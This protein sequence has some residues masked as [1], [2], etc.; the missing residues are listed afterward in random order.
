MSVAAMHW[1]Y[2]PSRFDFDQRRE[3]EDEET[4]KKEYNPTNARFRTTICRHWKLKGTCRRGKYCN[5]AH[6]T[7]Q[8]VCVE[9]PPPF[10]VTVGGRES[11]SAVKSDLSISQIAERYSDITENYVLLD[12]AEEVVE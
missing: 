12:D 11:P 3:A 4:F 1:R 9:I 7:D 10:H 8:L 5:F 2:K 6:G